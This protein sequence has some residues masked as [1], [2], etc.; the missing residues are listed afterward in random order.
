MDSAITAQEIGR[1]QRLFHLLV[2]TPEVPEAWQRLVVEQGIA[3]KQ[4]HDAHLVAIM[5]VNAVSS[6]L[7]FNTP[8]TLSGLQESM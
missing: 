1:L 8:L 7:T 3:G 6:I 2:Y 5:R 4:T